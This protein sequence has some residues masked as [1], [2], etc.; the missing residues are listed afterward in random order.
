MTD[1][2]LPDA[3]LMTI[4]EMIHYSMS[5]VDKELVIIILLANRTKYPKLYLN[6]SFTKQQ[7]RTQILKTHD[8]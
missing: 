8:K 6:I 2:D 5:N 1:E 3:T 7:K 4:A